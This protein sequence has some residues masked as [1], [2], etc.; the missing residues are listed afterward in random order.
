MNEV[1]TYPLVVVART[2][3]SFPDVESFSKKIF[4]VIGAFDVVRLREELVINVPW[5]PTLEVCISM[6]VAFTD[7]IRPVSTRSKVSGSS[8]AYPNSDWH[9]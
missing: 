2:E 3:V 5:M 8:W 9:I 1:V 4:A 7:W 6:F